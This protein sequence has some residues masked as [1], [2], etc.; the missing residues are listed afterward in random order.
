[1]NEPKNV[2][3]S[4][5]DAFAWRLETACRDFEALRDLIGGQIQVRS[6]SDGQT[7]RAVAAIR[8]ALAQSF[9]FN[10]RR[11][12]RICELH[13]D[14]VGIERSERSR[15]MNAAKSIIA[16][17][18]VNEHGSDGRE[19]DVRPSMRFHPEGAWMDETAL[20]CPNREMILV[21]AINLCSVYKAVDHTRKL[22]G[23][24]ARHEKKLAQLR[25]QIGSA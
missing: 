14:S 19:H 13:K 6:P 4:P 17:R 9:I 2:E 11:A 10:T 24:I 25:N 7:S 18:D 3:L 1:M 8:M 15:F 23:F 16:L 12:A 20:N 5:P 21:G 22:A